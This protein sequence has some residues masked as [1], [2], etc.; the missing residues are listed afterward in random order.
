[1]RFQ[2]RSDDVPTKEEDNDDSARRRTLRIKVYGGWTS[3]VQHFDETIPGLP[4]YAAGS[5][6]GRPWAGKLPML[7]KWLRGGLSYSARQVSRQTRKEL[8]T[9]NAV[10]FGAVLITY[11]W[12]RDKMRSNAAANGE[13]N[14]DLFFAILVL[15]GVLILSSIIMERFV[16]LPRLHPGMQQVTQ[17]LGPRFLAQGWKLEY[18]VQDPQ[19]PLGVAAYFEITPVSED[20][21]PRDGTSQQHPTEPNRVPALSSPAASSQAPTEEWVTVYRNVIAYVY[22]YPCSPSSSRIAFLQEGVPPSMKGSVDVFVWGTLVEELEDVVY[23]FHGK[24]YCADCGVAITSFFIYA[25]F[26]IGSIFLVV[27]MMDQVDDQDAFGTIGFVVGLYGAIALS[28]VAFIFCRMV[29]SA[30]SDGRRAHTDLHPAA[31]DV[32]NQN[33]FTEAFA[34]AGYVVEYVSDEQ[35]MPSQYLDGCCIPSR[36]GRSFVRF[37]PASMAYSKISDGSGSG[38]LV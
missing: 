22:C 13:E 20:G 34:K 4:V 35:P 32:V 5:R 15:Y 25:L 6:A 28:V 10:A 14:D 17:D 38:T 1:M 9:V 19:S 30:F 12:A 16:V 23:R 11:M 21:P 8:R 24:K 31:R 26:A 27:V 37:V 18:I 36:S 2:K 7:D 3:Q 29:L 33:D